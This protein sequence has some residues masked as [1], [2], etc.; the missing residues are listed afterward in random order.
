[1]QA[2]YSVFKTE[3]LSQFK[4]LKGN[5]M[6][7]QL[8][9]NRLVESIKLKNLLH[10]SPI[11]VNGEFNIID[12]QHRYMA[13]KQLGLPI[14][15]IIDDSLELGDIQV[16]NT[17]TKNWTTDDYLHAYIELG[18]ENYI[19]YKQFQDKFQLNHTTAQAF[20]SGSNHRPPLAFKKGEF[21]L[22]NYD[23]AV[24]WAEWLN[25]YK[26]HYKGTG[27]RSF[28]YAILS[29]FKH[30]EYDHVR[31]MDRLEQVP[32]GIQ[33]THDTKG[34]LRQL[35]DIFNYKYKSDRVRFF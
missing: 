8:H 1:M 29:V 12:G 15:Y 19:K 11:V 35:E 13:A 27:R 18:V 23:Q 6:V 17:N 2:E 31:M 33:D 34:Y 22:G 16:L 14:F 25:D 26:R 21:N 20:L 4:L 28:V 7:N 10:I 5:R 3:D 32:V 30:G 9:L 24:Q